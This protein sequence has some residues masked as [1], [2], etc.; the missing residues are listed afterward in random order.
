MGND[1]SL[2]TAT[3][4]DDLT[5]D[6]SISEKSDDERFIFHPGDP[7]GNLSLGEFFA[8]PPNFPS[9]PTHFNQ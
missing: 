7:G 2:F 1:V 3:T 4:A 6:E 9:L 5:I 8:A